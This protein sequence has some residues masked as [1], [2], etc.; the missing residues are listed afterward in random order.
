MVCCPH[1]HRCHAARHVAI[2]WLH[3]GPRCAACIVAAA[4]LPV[5]S[6]SGSCVQQ[7]AA[8]HIAATA[9]LLFMLLSGNCVLCGSV[10]L[11]TFLPL[12]LLCCLSSRCWAIV[13]HAMVR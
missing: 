8:A 6:L 5:V 3:V 13:C 2:E 10:P 7:C 4:A 1:C 12:Q 9:A 11:L